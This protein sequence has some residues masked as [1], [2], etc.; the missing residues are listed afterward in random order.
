MSNLLLCEEHLRRSPVLP[1]HGGKCLGLFNIAPLRRRPDYV[2]AII[3]V[4][5]FYIVK[6]GAKF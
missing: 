1:D 5:P 2:D 6:L 3:I 4:A